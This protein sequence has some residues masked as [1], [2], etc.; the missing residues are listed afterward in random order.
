MPE[1][2]SQNINRGEVVRY[3]KVQIVGKFANWNEDRKSNVGFQIRNEDGE[4]RRMRYEGLV[5]IKAA[6]ANWWGAQSA[7]FTPKENNHV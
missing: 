4:Y 3:A 1:N 6:W 5:S 2:S 7:P